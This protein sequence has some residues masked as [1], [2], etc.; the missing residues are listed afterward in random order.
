M[1]SGLGLTAS[2]EPV[3]IGADTHITAGGSYQL[4]QGAINGVI[5]LDTDAAVTLVGNGATSGS[6][7][8]TALTIDAI[9]AGEAPNTGANLTL[10]DVYVSSPYSGGNVIN[11]TGPGN[12]LNSTGINILES[13]GYNNA[14]LVHVDLKTS[15]TINGSPTQLPPPDPGDFAPGLYLYKSSVAAAVGGNGS[16]ACGDITF[17][18]GSVFAK[19][20]QTG[21]VIGGDS[22]ADI[23]GDITI[24]G[25][26][27][28]IE[29]N[30]RGAA[31]GAS[32]QGQC[33]G[34]VYITGGSTLINV[35][36]SGS[37]I[38]RGDSGSITGVLHM[39]GGS[40]KTVVDANAAGTWG[41]QTG[42]DTISNIAI[43]AKM[44]FEPT[45]G[46]G[47]VAEVDVA[48]LLSND[49]TAPITAT[50]TPT[51]GA[52]YTVYNAAGLN[53]YDYTASQT[54]TPSNWTSNTKDDT[55]LYL[56][57]P[58]DPG[59]GILTV[60]NGVVTQ[61]YSY[62][63]TPNPPNEPSSF[64]LTPITTQ[65]TVT[66]AASTST[67]YVN[68][69]A[70][71]SVTVA[72]GDT[73]DFSVVP[74]SGQQISGVTINPTTA[75][76]FTPDGGGVY[77]LGNIQSNVTVTVTTISG[78]TYMIAFVNDH[79]TVTLNG[80]P[81]TS[82]VMTASDT[83]NFVVTPD[84]GYTVVSVEANGVALTPSGGVY[85]LSG[86]NE[87]TKVVITTTPI[88]VTHTVNFTADANSAA[89]IGGVIVTDATVDDGDSL[90]FNAVP[91]VGYAIGSVT[92]N[93]AAIQPDTQGNYTL[94]SVTSDVAVVISSG[95]DANSWAAHAETNAW[96]GGGTAAS[97]YQ[98]SSAGYLAKLMTEVNGGT[99]H[100]GEYFQLTTS[101]DLGNTYSWVP[102]G[103]GR[104]FNGSDPASGTPAFAGI[105]DGAGKTIS[106]LS[107]APAIFADG[108][109]GFG[110][111]G[112]VNGGAVQ[113]VTV[114]GSI[115]FT[116]SVNAVGGVVG[117]TTGGISNVTN[118]AT[119][120][121][122]G[123]TATE[124]GGVVGAVSNSAAA[125]VYVQYA[126][127]FGSVTGHNWLGGVVGAAFNAQE[128]G[129][130]I[131]RSFNAG[132]VNIVDVPNR[133][134]AGGVVGYT[135]GSVTN[136]YNV[137]AINLNNTINDKL[138]GGI[139]GLLYGESGLSAALSD[140]YSAGD[141]VNVNEESTFQPP[142]ALYASA[143]NEPDVTVSNSV[144]LNTQQQLQLG[145]TWSN[146][147]GV[148]Q[149]F[150]QSQS[151]IGANY[152]DTAYFAQYS[153]DYPVLNW[154]VTTV[155]TGLQSDFA[156]ALSGLTD[157]NNVIVISS[158]PVNVPSSTTTINI[159]AID[160]K[161][162][163]ASGYNSNLFN[164]T[165]TGLLDFQSGTIDGNAAGSTSVASS[166]ID[167]GGAGAQ[168]TI[169]SGATL[170]NNTTTSN[171]AAVLVNSGMLVMNGGTITGNIT[172][173]NG[174]AVYLSANADFTMN[175]G[176]ISSNTA[177]LGSGIYVTASGT[178]TLSPSGNDAIEFDASDDIYLPNT[179]GT[180][181]AQVSFNIS[182]DLGTGV[183]NTISLTI[184]NPVLNADIAIAAT[185][186]I[187][188]SSLPKLV[189]SGTTI[190]AAY[191]E[192]IYI[193]VTLLSV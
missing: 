30:A 126:A 61:S 24:S 94:A 90:T 178:L 7:P 193:T 128:G 125:P 84:T 10:Q 12:T 40:L 14:A 26:Q 105:F 88:A 169:G 68:G 127:N 28:C 59:A 92:A 165:G 66:F 135:Q 52:T 45:Q 13:N 146:V 133:S 106:S 85:T 44:V 150:L 72:P 22:T 27:L 131:D 160:G 79:S 141:F 174:G 86:V 154:Q 82:A 116:N 9:A 115:S 76:T 192:Y 107:I 8:N 176:K 95:V 60:T 3:S 33:A 183:V 1:F 101:I 81:V 119:V 168:L 142:Q 87:D 73:V 151:V 75:G 132:T 140:S 123:A 122:T 21:A 62:A 53:Q 186:S 112:Y 117:Y 74:N 162:Y 145:A 32:N 164:V 170:K 97:P 20:S 57:L 175:G 159:G 171:G 83:L 19:G 134:Y 155:D 121:V 29:A 152:L 56:Y 6:T 163:R 138:A 80:V 149:S 17:A 38:G 148:A 100:T 139:A 189:P 25:G 188:S 11:F 39:T 49:P 187:A 167:I 191:D 78:Q 179:V 58:I 89:A 98:V 51:G 99:P 93:G 177:A 136:C 65:Y 181:A 2:A 108:F 185:G 103:G 41:T 48:N 37:A 47:D 70:V 104:L 158:L 67:V 36:F 91:Y 129:V 35:D 96:V 120:S 77:T 184:P 156:T 43:T 182:A 143:D 18:G 69:Q 180:A 144:Y 5:Y 34:D 63:Y 111:F 166:L 15:L 16:E 157:A 55:K 4:D 124:T 137:G 50:I 23:N 147:N 46:Q 54:Y 114:E 118:K 109:G 31:I 130:I 110:L 161:I 64:T 71:T 190:L 113:N 172:T 102:I 42:V 153:A 173:G